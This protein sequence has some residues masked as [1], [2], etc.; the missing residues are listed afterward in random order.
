[1]KLYKSACSLTGAGALFWKGEKNEYRKS[2]VETRAF[3]YTGNRHIYWEI[4]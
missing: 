2:M 4:Q 3:L 1:M